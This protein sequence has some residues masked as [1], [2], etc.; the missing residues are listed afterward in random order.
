[1]NLVESLQGGSFR[2]YREARTGVNSLPLDMDQ[3]K[4]HLGSSIHTLMAIRPQILPVVGYSEANYHVG[5]KELIESCRIAQGAVR[6][7][8]LGLPDPLTDEAIKTRKAEVGDEA[9]FLLH[10]NP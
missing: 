5:P 9:P 4:G 3:A 1:M 2:V 10:A 7:A 6:N 8:L